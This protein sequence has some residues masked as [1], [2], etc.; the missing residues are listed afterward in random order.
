MSV[1]TLLVI[2]SI[3]FTVGGWL[4]SGRLVEA[5]LVAGFFAAA[6][7]FACAIGFDLCAAAFFPVAGFAFGAGFLA[8]AFLAVVFFTGFFAIISSPKIDFWG[9][10]L[11]FSPWLPLYLFLSFGNRAV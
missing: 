6:F 10:F 4:E 1:S 3:I 8:A 5:T 9:C 2:P 7:A 11:Q